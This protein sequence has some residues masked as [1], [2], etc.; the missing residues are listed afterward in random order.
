MHLLLRAYFAEKQIVK[1]VCPASILLQ[2]L[3][4]DSLSHRVMDV[5]W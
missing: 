5:R 3:D 4:A 1:H 2:L